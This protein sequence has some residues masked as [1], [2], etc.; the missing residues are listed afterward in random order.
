MTVFWKHLHG[1]AQ[2]QLLNGGYLA[3]DAARAAAEKQAQDQHGK[4]EGNRDGRCRE[5]W[6]RLAA[7][8]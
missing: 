2:G 7:Y 8:R 6:P 1:L 4:A 5:P 3:P